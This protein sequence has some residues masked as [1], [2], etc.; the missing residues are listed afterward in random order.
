MLING[1]SGGVGTFAVQLARAFGAAVTGVCS[2]RNVELVRTL[3]AEEVI[4]YTHDDFTRTGERYDLVLDLVGNRALGDLRRSVAPQGTLVLSGGA[5][6]KLLGPLPLMLGALVVARFV[7]QRLRTFLAQV[8]TEDL[9]ALTELIEAG[10]V[11][12]V[13]DREYPLSEAAAAIGYVEAG[14]ARGKVIIMV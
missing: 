2:A 13:I 14:H 1:A 8:R 4:D 10:K 12:P 3:G 5:G 7:G 11:T 9:R 6:D